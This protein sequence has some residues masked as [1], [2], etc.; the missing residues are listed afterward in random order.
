M[1]GIKITYSWGDEEP[2]E[3][4]GSFDTKEK[5]FEKIC[6]LAGREAY[7]QNEEFNVDNTCD[8]RFNASEYKAELTYDMDALEQYC[9]NELLPSLRAKVKVNKPEF[10]IESEGATITYQI[11]ELKRMAYGQMYIATDIQEMSILN[12]PAIRHDAKMLN[13]THLNAGVRGPR[14]SVC[15]D[16][17]PHR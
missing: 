5:A 7:V 3:Q 1:Y 6:E 12:E 13:L 9:V 8:I 2:L 14:S 4:Y 11:S 15:Q 16:C 17:I 10:I